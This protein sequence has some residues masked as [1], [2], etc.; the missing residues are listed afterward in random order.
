MRKC[1]S[2]DSRLKLY[3]RTSIHLQRTAQKD[4]DRKF[5]RRESVVK[6]KKISNRGADEKYAAR[7][8]AHVDCAE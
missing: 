3:D 7:F 1:L 8:F 6:L 2:R 5:V 4:T